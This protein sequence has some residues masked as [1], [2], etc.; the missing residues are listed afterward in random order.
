M[1]SCEYSVVCCPETWLQSDVYEHEM[2]SNKFNVFKAAR[3]LAALQCT[4]CGGVLAGAHRNF[5]CIEIDLAFIRQNIPSVDII[6]IK[7]KV[8]NKSRFLY[9]FVIYIPPGCNIAIYNLLYE[10]LESLHLIS[11]SNVCITGDFNIPKY[12]GHGDFGRSDKSLRY[13][14]FVIIILFQNITLFSI[15]MLDY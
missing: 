7:I 15:L 14:T 13:K 3:N 8:T 11:K 10:C 9:L 5:I 12:A 2:F 6:G 1:N 4:S